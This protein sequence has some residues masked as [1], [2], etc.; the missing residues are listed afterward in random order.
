MYQKKIKEIQEKILIHI[1][2][3]RDYEEFHNRRLRFLK[4]RIRN[5]ETYDESDLWNLYKPLA[6]TIHNR[7][8]AF[9]DSGIHSYPMGLGSDKW[10]L[11]LYKM[12]YAFWI[13][14]YLEDYDK[15][16]DQS[17]VDEG[18]SLFSEYFLHLWD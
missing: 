1:V 13:I 8:E 14:A 7:L 18:L 2:G 15:D 6:K 12:S 5:I 11:I 9:R 3:N 10:A 4:D 16:Y 17:I